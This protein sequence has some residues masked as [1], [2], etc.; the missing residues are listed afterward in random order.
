MSSEADI[1]N[2]RFWPVMTAIFFG[3]FLTILS[4][5]MIN[6]ALPDLI[7]HFHTNLS[8]IQWLSLIHI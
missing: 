2:I 5:S 7:V 1:K 3:S 6:I 8:T 4:I